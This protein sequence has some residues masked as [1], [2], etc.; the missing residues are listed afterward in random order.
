MPSGTRRIGETGS[1]GKAAHVSSGGSIWKGE[2]RGGQAVQ[3]RCPGNLE[4]E[5]CFLS[6]TVLFSNHRP[7]FAWVDATSTLA[8]FLP[9][10]CHS[11]VVEGR[12]LTQSN[13]FWLLYSERVE[14][15]PHLACFVWVCWPPEDGAE[16]TTHWLKRCGFLP[17]LIWAVREKALKVVSFLNFLHWGDG[18]SSKPVHIAHHPFPGLSSLEPLLAVAKI[19][20][21]AVDCLLS[22][23]HPNTLNKVRASV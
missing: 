20:I 10:H 18:S 16:I 23:P 5:R 3:W 12:D 15:Q 17:M 21:W 7:F 13:H 14:T 9:H 8:A 4:P 6:N 11:A 2:T 22:P 1:Q 19:S